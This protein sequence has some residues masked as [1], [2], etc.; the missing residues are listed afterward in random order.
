MWGPCFS[1]L[2]MGTSTTSVNSSQRL[3][4]TQGSSSRS[5][6][7]SFGTVASLRR[8][9]EERRRAILPR[10]RTMR[11]PHDEL[12]RAGHPV[13]LPPDGGGALDRAAARRAGVPVQRRVGGPFLRHDPASAARLRRRRARSGLS[14]ALPAP[15]LVPARADS[16]A[17]RVLRGGSHLLLVA[18]PEPPGELPLGGAR[19]ASPERGLQP[20]GRAPAGGPVGLDHLAVPPA[21]RV[22]RRAAGG[23]RH[24]GVV[25]HALPIL[26]P[27]RA[28]REA[29]LV[30]ARVQHALAASGASR[31]QS[32]L[33]RP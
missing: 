19:G 25:L 26:D 3:T 16:L 4:S 7:R 15:L 24:R 23:L 9:P 6:R 10:R 13:L 30:R 21:A 5:W 1:Q 18:P 8:P 32:A 29:G 17:G 20:C 31:H 11:A 22:D 2:P 33:P 12:H 27:H 14:L 28:G